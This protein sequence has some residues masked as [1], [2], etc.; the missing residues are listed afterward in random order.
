MIQLILIHIFIL[1]ACSQ[2]KIAFT[3][4]REIHV[5]NPDGSNVQQITNYKVPGHIPV[6]KNPQWTKDN[7]KILFIYDPEWHGGMSLYVMNADG[8]NDIRLTGKPTTKAN[9]T[10]SPAVSPDGKYGLFVSKANG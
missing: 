3:F 5:M 1:A 6:S 10:W 9:A 4:N 7:S 8:S 2:S